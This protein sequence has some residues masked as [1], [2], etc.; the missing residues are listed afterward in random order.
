MK[1][2][3][4]RMTYK[5]QRQNTEYYSG[6]IGNGKNMLIIYRVT[7]N[8]TANLTITFKEDGINKS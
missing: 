4:N 6:Q 5:R 7:V 1:L 2:S 8:L 3:D